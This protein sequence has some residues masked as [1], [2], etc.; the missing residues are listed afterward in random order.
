VNKND[1][2]D[3]IAKQS[4]TEASKALITEIIDLAFG[5]IEAELKNGGEARFVGFGTF[6]T[7]RRKATTG[8]NPRTGESIAIA[9]S[10][11]VKFTP[12]KELKAAVNK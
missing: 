1:L 9:A 11:R 4:K 10:T 2:I 3:F 12:G 8:R 6:K 7:T 5:G